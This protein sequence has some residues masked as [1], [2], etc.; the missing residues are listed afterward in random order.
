MQR[1]T[2]QFNINALQSFINSKSRKSQKKLKFPVCLFLSVTFLIHQSHARTHLIGQAGEEDEQKDVH[3]PVVGRVKVI[4]RVSQELKRAVRQR[5]DD[6]G[7]VVSV[8]LDEVVACDGRRVDVV[9][10]ERAD[11]SLR[12]T[13][14][15]HLYHVLIC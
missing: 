8:S 9:L 3:L 12:Q 6:D 13:P 10:P 7:K 11:E 14:L 5:H 4:A 15:L 2:L 1:T